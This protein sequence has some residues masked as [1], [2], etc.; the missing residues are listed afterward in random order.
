MVQLYAHTRYQSHNSVPVQLSIQNQQAPS[1]F[2]LIT[3]VQS[4][5]SLVIL[6]YCKINTRNFVS[7]RTG[8]VYKFGG[9]IRRMP[10]LYCYL[11]MLPR[12][13]IN[14]NFYITY[15]FIFHSTDLIEI[16]ILRRCHNNNWYKQRWR[17]NIKVSLA[18]L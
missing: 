2:N 4:I 6:K 8:T 10:T 5:T 13:T 17:R 18:I 15:L 7:V 1:N 14:N 9:Y 16:A 12:A 11:R 3:T